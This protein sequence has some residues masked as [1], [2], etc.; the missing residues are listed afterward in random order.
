MT[1]T[2][3]P[4]FCGQGDRVPVKEKIEIEPPRHLLQKKAARR[5]VCAPTAI[6]SFKDKLG[7]G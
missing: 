5:A 4:V 6:G 2:R 1:K 3:C 7:N